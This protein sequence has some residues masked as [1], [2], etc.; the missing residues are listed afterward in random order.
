ML[1]NGDGPLPG[2]KGRD[3]QSVG[4][5][6]HRR[7]SRRRPTCA[8]QPHTGPG[9]YPRQRPPVLVGR[10]DRSARHLGTVTGGGRDDT[11]LSWDDWSRR[12]G[13]ERDFNDL[14]LRSSAEV[15]PAAD[16]PSPD[17]VSIPL[18]PAVIQGA[19]GIAGVALFAV[20]RFRRR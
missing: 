12:E 4:V 1:R 5:L 11:L 15:S 6:Q 17:V 18:P 16:A 3:V 10:L 19:V 8:R 13:S 9:A 2:A 14:V 7:R 20:R